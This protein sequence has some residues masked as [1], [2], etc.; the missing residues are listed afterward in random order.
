M[1]QD[2]SLSSRFIGGLINMLLVLMGLACLLPFIHVL[3]NSLSDSMASALV[4]VVFWP[5]GFTLDNYGFLLDDRLFVHSFTITVARVVAGVTLNVLITI[6]TAYPLSRVHIHMPGRTLFKVTLLFGML[7]NAGLIPLFLAIRNLGLYNNFLVLIL[8]PALSVFSI[9]VMSGFFHDIPLEFE[10]A[11]VLEGASDLIVLFRV[12]VPL[13]LPAIAMIALFSAVGHWNAW[14]D[15]VLFM[16]RSDSWPLQSYLYSVVTTGMAV[17]SSGIPNLPS[18]MIVVA[19]IPI[20]MVYPILQRY[21]I[22]GLTVGGI[23]G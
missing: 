23:N 2:R 1:I 10:E 14:F 8:P 7:F 12:F 13:S 19:T 21:F 9:I 3:A 22:T 4:T 16:A 15:G 6:L 18:A 20:A 17:W 5:V 11:A